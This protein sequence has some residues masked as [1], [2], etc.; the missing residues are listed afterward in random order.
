M[1]GTAPN[2]TASAGQPDREAMTPKASK[3]ILEAATESQPQLDALR[4][5]QGYVEPEQTESL[6]E[7]VAWIYVFCRENLFRDDTDLIS[8]TLWPGGGPAPG[9]KMMEVG[10]GPGFYS[11]RFARR[12]PQLSVVGVDRSTQQLDWAQ[13]RASRV[14]LPNCS[15]EQGNALD[16][17]CPGR[18]VRCRGR[19]ASLHRAPGTRRSDRGNASC[20][21][22]GRSLFR[23]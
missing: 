6:F 20:S 17:R 22:A 14:G 16:L 23:G 4:E 12:F 19:L 7:Q 9:T 2:W 21:S 15:F 13:R 8:A 1:N 18:S 5:L 3:A 10:C 11:C